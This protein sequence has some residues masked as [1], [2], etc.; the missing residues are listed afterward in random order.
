MKRIVLYALIF[1]LA[2]ASIL[3]LASCAP[4]APECPPHTDAGEDGICD[5]CG[6]QIPQNPPLS[7]TP[8]DLSAIVFESKRITYS[9]EE[10]SI[11]IS[12]ELPLGVSAEYVGNGKVDAGVYEVVVKFYYKGE[13]LAHSALSATLTIDKATIDTSG[14]SLSATTGVYSGVAHAPAV[15]GSLP[16]GVSTKCTYFNEVAEEVGEMVEAGVYKV[17][18][19]FVYDAANYNEPATKQLDYTIT[20]ATYDM[21]GVRLL[22]STKTYDG[23][24][25]VPILIGVLPDGVL[26]SLTYK[27]SQNE[28]V[29][30]MVNPGVY[31]AYASFTSNNP[32]YYPILPM[33]ATVTI[34]KGQIGGISFTD[35][36]FTYDGEEKS[37]LVSGAPDWLEVTYSGNGVVMPGT[38]KVIATFAEVEN[39]EPLAPME[40]TITIR[41][42]TSVAT[43]GILFEEYQGGYAVSGISADKSVVV[44]PE[45]YN[46]KPVLSIKSFAFDGH[47]EISYVYIPSSV[48]NVGNGAFRGCAG[49]SAL[50]LGGI[51]VIGQEAFKGTGIKELVLPESL[52]SIG[53]GAFEGTSIEKVTLPFIGG[54]RHSSNA[55]L[56]FIFGGSS[57]GANADKVPETLST[58]I[59]S[60]GCQSIPPR[61]FYGITSLKEVVIGRSVTEI[62]NGAF[63][64]CSSLREI[65]IPSSL[66]AIPANNKAENSPFF[67][68]AYDMM[69]V[70]EAEALPGAWGQY[71]A[72][73]AEGKR[74][75]VIYGKSYDDYVMNKNEY[76]TVDPTDATL[77]GIF[78]GGY[79]MS[80]FG[81]SVYE[82][83]LDWNI[84]SALPEID[85]ITS[86][87]TAQLAVVQASVSNGN[88]ATITVTSMDG[89]YTLVYKVKF[90]VSGSFSSSAEVVNKNGASGTVTFVVDDGYQPTATFMKSMMQKYANLAVT[91]AIATKNFLGTSEEYTT[92]N[93]LIIDDIDGDGM[94]EYV[95]DE[96]G[97][98]TYIRNEEKIDFW[99][100]IVSVGRSE[101]IAHSHTHAFWGVNDEGGAQLTAGASGALST[102]IYSSLVE[103]SATKE[104]YASTQIVREIFGDSF[105]SLT[106]VNGGIPPKETDTVVTDETRVYLSKQTVRVLYDT[107]VE[108]RDGK[109]YVTELTWVNLQSTVGTIPA[110]TDIKTT[111]DTSSGKIPAGTPIYLAS[112]YVTVPVYDAD[113]NQNVVKGFKAY[114]VELYKKAL[115]DGTIIGARTSGQKVYTASDFT[116]LENRILRKAYIIAT[117]T[118]GPMPAS[119]KSHID[120]AISK[121][122]WASF[123]IHAMTEKTDDDSQGA[124]NITW[125]QAEELFKYASDKGD[126]L[127]IATQTDATMYYHQWSTSTVSTSYDSATGKIS[128]TL[129]DEENDELYTMPLTVKVMVPGIWSGA[130]LGGE[131]LV[132][133]EDASGAR[134]VYV[135]VAP[136]STVTLV[137]R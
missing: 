135:D 52:E 31:T 81:A 71:F 80:A 122:G 133:R 56:G 34:N 21:S 90:N 73:T 86:V 88:I 63:Q 41:V 2:C 42:D 64:G 61:A 111:A 91:Y 28:T 97:K 5:V 44:I 23:K 131:E 15:L 46:N 84:N 79:P 20:K 43:D 62:G 3:A 112:D 104:V 17:V 26:P 60:N 67:G 96:N 106:Y 27:N 22:S 75:L 128:V 105:T 87:P 127:W 110:D 77:S 38:Y 126:E 47:S 30:E 134:Y 78:V 108:I 130:S 85:A 66:T 119:W 70:L 121:G 74:A 6:D 10:Y 35:A 48:I 117:S 58:V 32:N 33:S 39:Y 109:I 29:S 118:D 57:Y 59:I 69:L 50:E 101:I 13:E 18:V 1:I 54:S 82:Y 93:G 37:I 7:D 40:A 45:S 113:G 129:T 116:D 89:Q 100:D 24:A 102:R 76:R 11:F 99:R 25:I 65:Y 16:D 72:Y 123:C 83:T 36:V 115:A 68:T 124:H 136:E 55:Y 103:G 120:S 94:M 98:Y 8:P 19:D 95:L 51:K 92:D 107:P 14:L 4:P 125:T 132:V 12:G 53:Y 49:L 114:I 9:G 137:G